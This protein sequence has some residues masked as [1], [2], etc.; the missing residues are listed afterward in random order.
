MEAYIGSNKAVVLLI[1]IIMFSV[2]VFSG[3]STRERFALSPGIQWEIICPDTISDMT[4]QMEEDHV[5]SVRSR[6]SPS[7]TTVSML[8]NGM[9]APG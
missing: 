4:S 2:A 5:Y 9:N 7:F 1:V 6:I 3:C 8:S